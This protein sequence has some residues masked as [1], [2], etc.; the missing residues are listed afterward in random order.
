M[1]KFTDKARTKVLRLGN[2]LPYS[3]NILNKYPMSE[4]TRRRNYFHLAGG[5]QTFKTYIFYLV[6]NT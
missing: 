3:S 6:Y 5:G 4:Y 1:M 2:N